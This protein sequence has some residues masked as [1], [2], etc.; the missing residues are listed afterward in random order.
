MQENRINTLEDEIRKLRT[1]V[2][3]PNVKHY[4]TGEYLS[5]KTNTNNNY[6]NNN[7]YGM[8]VS[9]NLSYGFA[10]TQKGKLYLAFQRKKMMKSQRI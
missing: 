8:P 4:D 2:L 7:P 9:N 5:P 1:L 3:S 6:D 10:L